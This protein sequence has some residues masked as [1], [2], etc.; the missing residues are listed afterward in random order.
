[1]KRLRLN[2]VL[3]DGFGYCAELLHERIEKD[4]WGYPIVSSEPVPESMMR[5]ARKAVIT[6]PRN[7]LLLQDA[8]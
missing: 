3:C 8:S 5:D 1:M 7:A 6:C 4:D 2:P